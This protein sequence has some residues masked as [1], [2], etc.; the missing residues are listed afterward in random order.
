MKPLEVH[1]NKHVLCLPPE[2]SDSFD[3]GVWAKSK[4][5]LGP[6]PRGQ[7]RLSISKKRQTKEKQRRVR[8]VCQESWGG[9]AGCR[10]HQAREGLLQRPGERAGLK[11][12]V[13]QRSSRSRRKGLPGRV[14]GR[15]RSR[16]G[17]VGGGWAEGGGHTGDSQSDDQSRLQRPVPSTGA[18]PPAVQPP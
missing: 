3:R 18:P 12:T 10:A 17:R 6:C 8:R 1:S 2:T 13:T 14:P 15:V 9:G 4:L 11:P 5:R 7:T 16:H